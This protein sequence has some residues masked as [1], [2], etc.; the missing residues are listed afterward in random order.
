MLNWIL[1]SC[2]YKFL[3]AANASNSDFKSLSF[4]AL[5]SL[6]IF[7]SFI[8]SWA[9]SLINSCRCVALKYKL[10][11]VPVMLF[12]TLFSKLF[13]I[14]EF[15]LVNS[16][17]RL[18]R[19]AVEPKL[20]TF[21]PAI[22]ALRPFIVAAF[23]LNFSKDFQS[24]KLERTIPFINGAPEIIGP[25]K[26]PVKAA[27]STPSINWLILFFP[28]ITSI[29]FWTSCVA[30]SLTYSVA[31]DIGTTSHWALKNW[32][33]FLYKVLVPAFP[34]SVEALPSNLSVGIVPSIT[35]AEA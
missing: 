3:W 2:W 20:S 5:T 31:K 22:E 24:E 16:W 27:S 35:S 15:S 12:N 6:D 14:S 19:K 10:A 8:Y 33:M 23:F 4:S 34:S 26:P 32:L 29:P 30:P 11:P 13:N 17:T 9:S 1:K 28:F 21:L 18:I 7:L 25:S